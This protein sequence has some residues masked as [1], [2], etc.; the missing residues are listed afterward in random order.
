MSTLKAFTLVNGYELIGSLKKET[1]ESYVLS[2]P[3]GIQPQ[4]TG[5]DTY[6][7]IL[8][9]M[10]AC[11]A[12]GDHIFYKHAICSECVTIPSEIEKAYYKRTSKIQI[13]GI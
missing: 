3:L 6:G 2:E 1:E 4:Q 12:T 10:S 9:P 13:V 5:P 7:L 11:N 8:V